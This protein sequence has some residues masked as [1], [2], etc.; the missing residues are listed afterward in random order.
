VTTFVE[1][2]ENG[3]PVDEKG[4]PLNWFT[5][6]SEIES[7]G[8]VNNKS[9]RVINAQQTEEEPNVGVWDEPSP[10]ESSKELVES[11]RKYPPKKVYPRDPILEDRFDIE[12]KAWDYYGA[13]Q[14]R[15]LER[16]AKEKE[17]RR[18]ELFLID[19]RRKRLE[20]MQYDLTTREGRILESEPY[21][22]LAKK[23]A[24]MKLTFEDALPWIETV[25]EVAQMYNMDSK[26]A[27]ISVA[28]DIRLNKQLG[29]IQRQIERAN[30]E[31]AL[32]NM[33]TIQKQQALT[34]L[35]D[36][37]NRGVT[38]SQIVQLI[39]FASE[40]DR[41]WTTNGNLQQSGSSNL[42][43]NNTSIP[44]P[45]TNGNNLHGGNFSMNDLIKLNLL[46]STTSNMLNRMG[47]TH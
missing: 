14:T 6:G 41:Y 44:P 3:Y 19:T 45:L 20:Q 26:Q 40:W 34:L 10:T 15:I 21:L 35:M 43:N 31:L 5:N 2:L 4:A 11:P 38:E 17:R 36:L 37:S 25:E 29:G 16:I 30:Q 27:A 32:I 18:H 8:I 1:D 42:G 46:K 12:R 47:T 28:E 7:E 9:S 33:A 13:A 39:N 23:L 24:G 22:G